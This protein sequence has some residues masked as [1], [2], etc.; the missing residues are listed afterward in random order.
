M[1]KCER[2]GWV[3][4]RRREGRREGARE[5]NSGK[6]GIKGVWEEGGRGRERKGKCGRKGVG[7]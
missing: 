5:Y 3:E 7:E 4:G 1:R 6:G 2:G